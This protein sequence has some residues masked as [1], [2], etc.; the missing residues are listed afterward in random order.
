MTTSIRIFD[1]FFSIAGLILL[2]PLFIVIA[3]FIKINSRGTVFFRQQRVGKDNKDFTIYKFRTMIADAARPSS[4][5]TIGSKDKR[6]T[7]AGY[8]LRKYKLDELPQLINVLKG[9]MSMVGPRPELRE[10][11]D[12]YTEEQKKI[13]SVLP[14]ITDWASLQYRQENDLLAAA[15]DPEQYYIEKIMQAKLQLNKRY[16]ENKNIGNYFFIIF[17]SLFAIKK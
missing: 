7:T 8:Y 13:L 16:I 10:Y 6:I 1:I 17:Q 11:V 14:G 12:L 15:P 5:L 9:E 4:F 3:V 2:L